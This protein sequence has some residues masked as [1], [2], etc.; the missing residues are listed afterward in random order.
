[1]MKRLRYLCML[2]MAF[3]LAGNALAGQATV[4]IG[5][6]NNNDMIIM[7][8]L[9]REFEK[10]NP[11]I[12]L[13]WVVLEENTLRQRIT[14]DI[15]T[16]S[17]Q[18]DVMT[19]GLMEAPMWGEREWLHPL[20]N[21]PASYEFEDLIDSVRDGLSYNGKLFALPFYAESQMLFYRKDLFEKAG[22]TMPEKPTWDDV[23][24][25]AAKLHDPANGVY[26][27]AM[28][29]KPGW[30]ESGGQITPMA[31]SY[32]A[33]W[34]D[35]DW[36]PQFETPQ[37]KEALTKYTEMVKKYC[38]PGSTSNGFNECLM[39]FATGKAAMWSDA[40]IAA[41]FLADP[42][43]SSVIGKVGYARQPYGKFPLG[44]HYLWSWALAIPTSSKQKEA[45]Q[46]FIMWATSPEYINLVANTRGWDQVPAGTRKSLYKNPKYLD[47]APFAQMTYDMIMEA[48]IRGMTQEPVPY[49]GNS[50]ICLPEFAGIGNFATQEYAAVMTGDK[51]VDQ[52]VKLVNEFAER[53]MREA[54]YYDK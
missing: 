37:F 27:I 28:R 47:A 4:T 11:D 30:G 18:F 36:K 33:R 1:M 9:S 12:K 23:E 32:G 22:L 8:E 40:T 41:A 13:N 3:C 43:Q 34:F 26:G 6:I 20:T 5:T 49:V 14:T 19:I 50:Y 2:A 17:G 48:K 31:Y 21:F 35:M 29:G 38:P 16:N 25:F 53:T 10:H 44:H 42:D 52:A 39:V 51:T 45:A 54:G 24:N 7:Q 46:K 15:S